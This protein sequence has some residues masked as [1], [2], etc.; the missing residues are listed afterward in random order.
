MLA[1]RTVNSLG[2]AYGGPASVYTQGYILSIDGVSP[3]GQ[4]GRSQSK[5]HFG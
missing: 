3:A 5:T 4:L 2:A 1:W